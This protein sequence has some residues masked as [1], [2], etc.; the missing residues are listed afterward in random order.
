MT[1][2]AFQF[3][4]KKEELAP[5][6]T[7]MRRFKGKLTA[8]NQKYDNQRGRYVANPQWVD[9][10]VVELT[11][12][13]VYPW[14]VF[15]LNLNA[16]DKAGRVVGANAPWG[17]LLETL[18]EGVDSIMD[19]VGHVTEMRA[20][21]HVYQ[22][23]IEAGTNEDGTAREASERIAGLWWEVIGVDGGAGLASAAS[24]DPDQLVLDLVDG[25]NAG[26]FSQAFLQH[27]VLK[28]MQTA[29]MDGSLLAGLVSTGK[30]TL[31]GDV[32]HVAE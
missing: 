20:H 11:E 1:N 17:H 18:P 2:Q 16:S 22:D 24:Q 5:S 9:V 10:E 30:L 26:E 15:E 6:G 25:K 19:L 4:T 21:L 31:D 29:L 14:E 13:S 8:V 12:G 32:Y 27:P 7:P 23:A 3:P 28:P